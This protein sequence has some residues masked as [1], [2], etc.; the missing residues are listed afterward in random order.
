MARQPF[1]PVAFSRR[2]YT[3]LEQ[4]EQAVLRERSFVSIALSPN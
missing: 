1:L 4:E 3:S 2:Q